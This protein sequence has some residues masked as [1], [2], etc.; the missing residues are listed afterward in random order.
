MWFG[1]P[2]VAPTG[3]EADPFIAPPDVVEN[4]PVSIAVP[5]LLRTD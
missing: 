2:F 1:K 4:L 3:V 5:I